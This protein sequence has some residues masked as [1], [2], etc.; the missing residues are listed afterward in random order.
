MKPKNGVKFPSS[1]LMQV[2]IMNGDEHEMH[3]LISNFGTGIIDEREPSGLPPVMR[4]IFEGQ[5][6]S[7]QVLIDAGADL[8]ACDTEDWNVLHVAAAM[9]DYEAAELIISSCS[10]AP[11]LLQAQNVCGE[12]PVDL[13]EEKE[14]KQLLSPKHDCHI[15]VVAKTRN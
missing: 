8:T 4:A 5:I 11:A 6:R 2:A 7:L 13:A 1:V 15:H 12:K 14:I 9:D 3:K 10:N